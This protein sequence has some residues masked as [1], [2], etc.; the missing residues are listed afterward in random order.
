MPSNEVARWRQS[1]KFG[2][3]M[4]EPWC[5]ARKTSRSGVRIGQRPHQ[6]RIRDREHR[7]RRADAEDEHGQRGGREAG[8]APQQPRTVSQVAPDRVEPG[9]ADVTGGF[10]RLRQ[11]S[12]I[13]DGQPS[14]LFRRDTTPAVRFDLA[15]EV[16]L[17][18]LENLAVDPA[19][20]EQAAQRGDGTLSGR[21]SPFSQDA[22]HRQRK[23]LPGLGFRVEALTAGAA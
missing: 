7:R 15:L 22:P 20:A 21:S 1:S 23:L 5:S 12:Q 6:H 2:H 10:D 17:E 16:I 11:P 19:A 9:R 3:A 13:A 4:P 14:S 18:L 8:R